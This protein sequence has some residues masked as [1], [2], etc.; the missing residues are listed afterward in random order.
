MAGKLTVSATKDYY[1]FELRLDLARYDLVMIE[2]EGRSVF[3][4]SFAS[5]GASSEVCMHDF[6]AD[7]LLIGTLKPSETP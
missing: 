4:P 5:R 7:A 2:L 3:R 6:N 1:R